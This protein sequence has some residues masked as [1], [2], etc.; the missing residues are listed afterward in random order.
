MTALVGARKHLRQGTGR[1]FRGKQVRR[2]KQA[3]VRREEGPDGFAASSGLK[4]PDKFQDAFQCCRFQRSQVCHGT[5]TSR[6]G[7]RRQS[8]AG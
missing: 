3:K 5:D 4:G 7:R 2:L 1:P 6:P 8:P